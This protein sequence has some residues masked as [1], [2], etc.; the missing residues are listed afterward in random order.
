[1]RKVLSLVLVFLAFASYAQKTQLIKGTVVDAETNQPLIGASVFVENPDLIGASTDLDGRFRLENV[2][3]GRLEVK[4]TYIGYEAWT[5]GLI[6]LTSG[7]ELVVHIGLQGSVNM[8]EEVTVKAVK[9]G[10]TKNDLIAISARSFDIKE[11]NRF[12]GSI[13]DPGRV[14]LNVAGVT[15][16][17]DNDNDVIIRGNS[18][19]GV[20]WRLE[21]VDVPNLSHFSRPGSSGG[22]ISALSPYVMG[23]T[24]FSTGAFPAEYGNALSGVFDIG[25]RKGNTERHE[26]MIRTGIIGL[27]A[28]AEGPLSHKENNTGS[29]LFNYRYSTLGILNSI[30]LHI[31]DERTDNTFQDLSFNIQLPTSK[32]KKTRINIFGIGGLSNEEAAAL[33]DTSKWEGYAEKFGTNFVTNFGVLGLSWTQLIDE[34]SYLKTTIAG[35]YNDIIEEEDTLSDELVSFN[36]KQT[37]FTET[38]IALGSYYNRKIIRLLSMRAGLQA[39]EKFFQFNV[40]KWIDSLQVRKTQLNGNGATTVIQPY[41]QMKYR[42]AEKTTLI[43]G[44]HAVY[45]A[46]NNTYSVE[47]RF[48]LNQR[49]GNFQKISFAYGLHGQHLPMGSYFTEFTASDGSTF[50]PNRNLEMMKNH[51]FILSYELVFAKHHRLRI[52]PFYQYQQNL[53]VA[54]NLDLTTMQLN[55]RS[56]FALDSMVSEGTGQNYGVDVSLGKGYHNHWFYLVNGSYFQSTYKALNGQMYSTLYNSNYSVSAMGGY[57]FQFKNSTLELGFRVQYSGGFR[58]TPIDLNASVA[59]KEGI[60]IESEAFTKQYP[61]YFRPD[62]RVAYKQNKKKYSWT[63]SLDVGNVIDRKNV[64]RQFYNR[65][66]HEIDFKYQLGLLPVIAFQVDFFANKGKRNKGD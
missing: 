2:P 31:V 27:N 35:T 5:G 62:V 52:E 40:E 54:A 65:D 56:G 60:E 29:Y 13:N 6:T 61:A 43:A 64:L 17:Q 39:E 42:P 38:R 45:L 57:E 47:P 10:E 8:Q 48:S 7:K 28:G 12:A 32:N 66:T 36:L 58:Y 3:V 15:S 59:A 46:F 55:I 20:L 34:K 4:C 30:G 14:V 11:T 25:F 37:G 26:F 51:H 21:G 16:A 22:G 63:I 19:V 23:N 9:Q 44:V 33:T 49:I 41:F 24:D 1:M 50:N 53:P 18:A